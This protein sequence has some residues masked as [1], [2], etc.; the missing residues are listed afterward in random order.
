[1]YGAQGGNASAHSTQGG[2]GGYSYGNTT[3][4]TAT[5]WF[6]YVGGQGNA[7]TASGA[8]K[9]GYNGGGGIT[10]EGNWGSTANHHGTG[11]GA[12]DIST[13]GGE[14]T[15]DSYQRYVR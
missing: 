6:I 10:G 7:C 5:T 1:M 9:G 2:L 12:T 15:I 4:A 11:G 13:V 8:V 3:I 14:C